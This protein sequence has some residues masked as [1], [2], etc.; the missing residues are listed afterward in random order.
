M[1]RAEL[2]TETTVSQRSDAD[3]DADTD[4]AAHAAHAS[5]GD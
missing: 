3:A 5:N 1:Y 4:L 2:S